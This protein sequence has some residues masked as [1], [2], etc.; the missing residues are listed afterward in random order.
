[1]SGLIKLLTRIP[2]KPLV[3]LKQCQWQRPVSGQDTQQN[4]G[5]NMKKKWIITGAILGIL[6][7][8][9]PVEASWN[10]TGAW[11]GTSSSGGDNV[12]VDS[13]AVTNP[14]LVSTGDIDVINTANT[15]TF[16]INADKIVN[17]DINTAAAI[18][19][20]KIQAA[21]LTNSGV[22]EG[23]TTA[24]INTGTDTTR[25][26]PIDQ[27]EASSYGKRTV[28]VAIN[29]ATVLTSGDG[30]AYFRI[31]DELAGWSITQVRAARTAGNDNIN[32]DL[33]NVTQGTDTLST[34][35]W[36]DGFETDSNSAGTSTVINTAEDDA[37]LYDRYRIDCN[38]AGTDTTWA[39]VQ[40]TFERVP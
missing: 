39:E 11:Q 21:S 19:G 17:A 27:F 2:V 12:S 38:V 14:D 32:F 25:Y 31:P 10:N 8:I 7:F 40:V 22:S 5:E 26:M 33:Y 37:T 18:A 34:A 16:N 4:K 1:M 24:E 15:V 36:I 23:A 20:S 28:S 3:A 30:K 9:A 6:G 13:V 29:N 35:V